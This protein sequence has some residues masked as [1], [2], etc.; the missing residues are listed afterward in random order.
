MFLKSKLTLN[1]AGRSTP[2]HF[3]IADGLLLHI[4]AC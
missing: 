2:A 3:S 1:V 4:L